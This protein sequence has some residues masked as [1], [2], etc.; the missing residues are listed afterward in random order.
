MVA[1][2]RVR[3]HLVGKMGGRGRVGKVVALERVNKEEKRRGVNGK[4][5]LWQVV[6]LGRWSHWQVL[7]YI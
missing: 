7:L 1:L 5:S 3:V 4:W 2:E 6:A